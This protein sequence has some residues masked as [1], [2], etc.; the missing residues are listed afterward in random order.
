MFVKLYQGYKAREQAD[1]KFSYQRLGP[2]KVKRKIGNLAY[3]IGIPDNWRIRP[4]I[5]VA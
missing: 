1:R 5:L 3:D 2:F 4:V